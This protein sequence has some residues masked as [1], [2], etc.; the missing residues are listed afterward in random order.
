MDGVGCKDNLHVP[1]S[2]CGMYVSMYADAGW[3]KGV[4]LESKCDAPKKFFM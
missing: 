1:S 3:N 2:I 4:R